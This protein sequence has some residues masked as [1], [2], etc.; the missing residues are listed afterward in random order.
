M[1]RI[2]HKKLML[3]VIAI[4][5]CSMA[6]ATVVFAAGYYKTLKAHFNNIQIYRNNEKVQLNLPKGMHEPFIVDGYTYVPLRAVSEIFGAGIHWDGTNYRIDIDTSG[7]PTA[8]DINN[9][10]AMVTEKQQK[11][12]E[13]EAK[14]KELEEQ[15]S[16]QKNKTSTTL[17]EL[18]KQLNKYY[19]KYENIEFDI[20]L[21]GNKNDIEVRIYV[22]LY[23]YKTEWNK[24]S[25]TKIE[26]LIK[27]IVEDI[28]DSFAD[29]DIDGYIKDE[30]SNK[31]LVDF[32]INSKGKLIIDHSSKSSKL[33]DLE[34]YLNYYYDIY[35]GVEFSISLYGDEYDI[36]VDITADNWGKLGTTEK[37][38][39][40]ESIYDEILDEFPKA[41]VT[42][43]V[44]DKTSRK[45]IDFYFDS[46]GNVIIK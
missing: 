3:S 43:T 10:I 26:N 20:D 13:L 32:Y 19:G 33:S 11:I 31:I 5:I 27:Y 29:A 4:L 34:D 38:D 6:M 30:D 44:Y 16:Q 1:N 41:D 40:L 39:Y 21:I 8:E 17:A 25:K 14:V 15:L 23:D 2:K 18:E 37:E 42:G 7:Q 22:D 12:N 46:R 24:L 45:Y 35:K 36:E 9:L 28:Q